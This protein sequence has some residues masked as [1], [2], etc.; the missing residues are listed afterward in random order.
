MANE[1]LTEGLRSTAAFS[2][3]AAGREATG[4][5]AL[6]GA[7]GLEQGNRQSAIDAILRGNEIQVGA[8]VDL[9][10]QILDSL[11]QSSDTAQYGQQNYLQAIAQHQQLGMGLLGIGGQGLAGLGGPAG[12]PNQP[13][14]W[15]GLLGGLPGAIGNALPG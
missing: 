6:L 14:W 4:F 3:I 2:D 15:R 8:G 1:R 11:K 7:E 5:Q 12:L 9:Q 10:G 13:G